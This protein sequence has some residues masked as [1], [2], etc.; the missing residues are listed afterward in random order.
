MIW[1]RIYLGSSR[2]SSNRLKIALRLCGFGRD[3]SLRP[4]SLEMRRLKRAKNLMKSLKKCE[5][6]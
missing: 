5:Y 6:F 2:L 4:E 3:D 1:V